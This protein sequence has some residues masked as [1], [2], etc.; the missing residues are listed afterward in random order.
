[1][2]N[3]PQTGAAAWRARARTGSPATGVGARDYAAPQLVGQWSEAHARLSPDGVGLLVINFNTAR[4]TLRC[5]DSIGRLSKQPDWVLVLDNASEE[6]DFQRLLSG[7]SA[8]GEAEL[9]LYRSAVNLGFAGGTNF[10]IDQLLAQAACAFI[11]LLNNDAVAQ[12]GMLDGMLH[13]LSGDLRAG[14][15]GGRVHRLD[16]PGQVDTLGITLYASLMPADRKS[17]HD[18]YLGPTAG[19]WLM[20]R[21]LADRLLS[22]SGYCL[23]GRYFCYCEDTDLVLRAVLLGYRPVYLD[24]TLA[25]HEGQASTGGGYN[26]FIAYHGLR[27]TIWMHVKL[28][29]GR[30]LLKYG[31]FLLAAHMLSVAKLVL[32]GELALL[33]AIYKDALRRLPEFLGERRRFRQVRQLPVRELDALIAKSFYRRGY[34][35]FSLR[36]LWSKYAGTLARRK[37]RPDR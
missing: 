24:D 21:A 4:Q 35:A 12:E 32:N 22:V 8:I 37:D 34:L 36:Q 1:V 27:N 26:R 25:L 20:T 23:D 19:C 18:P 6:V 3:P 2:S 33:A 16:E 31:P 30:L 17:A 13:A 7:C 29:P 9:R 5:L 28:V 10:L 15:A 14:L 11:G